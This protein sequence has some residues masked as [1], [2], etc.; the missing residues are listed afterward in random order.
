MPEVKQQSDSKTWRCG[1]C[2]HILAK[3]VLASGS[4]LEIKCPSC[5]AINVREA[6]SP[7]A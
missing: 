6:I 1:K 3:I 7:L 5:K 4:I 2:G